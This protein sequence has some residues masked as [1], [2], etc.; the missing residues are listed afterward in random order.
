MSSILETVLVHRVG[1]C[2]VYKVSWE[3]AI[4]KKAMIEKKK[5]HSYVFDR[6]TGGE[7]LRYRKEARVGE[8]VCRLYGTLT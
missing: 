8:L 1:P 4:V 2:E 6:V 3:G 7:F 5:Y